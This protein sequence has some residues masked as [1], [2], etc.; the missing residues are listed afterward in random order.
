MPTRRVMLVTG[1]A[2]AVVALGAGWALTRAPKRARAPWNAASE[3][4]GDARLDALAYAI[5]APNPHNMQPWRIELDGDDGVRLFADPGRL[6]P[7]TDPPARQIMIGFGCFLELFR[8]AAAAKGRRADITPFPEGAPERLPD[9]R[10][11]AAMRLVEDGAVTIDP[12]FGAALARRT[13]R[14]P[15]DMERAVPQED[16]TA[17]IAATVP[18]VAAAATKE[19]DMVGELRALAADAWNIEWGHGPTRRESIA[20]T[21]IGKADVDA[22]PWGLSLTGP[23]MEGLNAAG[24]LTL[25]GMDE[26]GSSTYEQSRAFYGRACETAAAFI[27][28]V[29]AANTRVDQL[30]AGRAWV[31]IHLEA[32]RR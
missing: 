25:E 31:R 30:E 27:W 10:P 11:I 7:E 12:L 28:T 20:V 14:A 16:L 8:Q 1:A 3:G 13:N 22:D 15:Y 19:A 5:L 24:M 4:F 21:R 23:L 32:T 2:A 17:L 6:L 18:G 26:P 29:T 9:A